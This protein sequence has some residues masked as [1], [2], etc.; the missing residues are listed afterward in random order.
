MPSKKHKQ[1]KLIN[2]SSSFLNRARCSKC[3]KGASTY[4]SYGAILPYVNPLNF[5]DLSYFSN[6]FILKR[7]R[8]NSDLGFE[9][10]YSFR[11]TIKYASFYLSELGCDVD[12]YNTNQKLTLPN[13]CRDEFFVC[14]CSYTCWHLNVK[15][16]KA[17]SEIFNRKGKY[18]Y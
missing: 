18:F 14:P 16:V 2:I 11:H 15:S 13:N 1:F 8:D 10:K 5:I 4:Y 12:F 6:N 7:M 17:R 9:S 3:G